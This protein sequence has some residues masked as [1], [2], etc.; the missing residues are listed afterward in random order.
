MLS[1]IVQ[2]CSAQQ[3]CSDTSCVIAAPCGVPSDATRWT[4]ANHSGGLIDGL[5]ATNLLQTQPT[6]PQY[7]AANC[8]GA[9][10]GCHLWAPGFG[11]RNGVVFLAGGSAD[12]TVRSWPVTNGSLPVGPAQTGAGQCLTAQS[13]ADGG[14]DGP[15]AGD[16][17]VMAPCDAG[18]GTH[19]LHFAVAPADG[20]GGGGQAG[21]QA[22]QQLRI[23]S[24]VPIANPL[25]LAGLVPPPPPPPHRPDHF[26]SCTAGLAG[27][28]RLTHA[29]CNDSLP[30]SAR[31]DDL[32]AQL[33]CAEKAAAI[34]SAGAAVPRLGV[35]R[36]GSAED[37]HGV[38]GGCIPAARRNDP[39]SSSSTGC[40]TTFPA[41]PGLGAS[42]DRALWRAVGAAIGVEARGLN[43]ERVGPLYFLDPDINLL[44]D[45]EQAAAP[46]SLAR[47]RPLAADTHTHASFPFP[48]PFR[49]SLGP[50]PRSPRRVPVSHGRVR[51]A[52]D[53]GHADGSRGRAH[54]RALPRRGEH[55]EALSGVR[56]RGL[57][58]QSQLLRHPIGRGVR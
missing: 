28:A 35:P 40:P 49:S 36:L 19:A 3:L 9:D 38:G 52:G 1:L 2:L 45:R 8:P 23:L 44:R 41:G 56:L 47:H 54:R 46:A 10:K 18:G 12:F 15:S 26:Y 57:P 31:L 51:R 43:N 27:G 16:V 55:D 13:V 39:N 11:D 50:R 48:F 17:L 53:P 37:T 21:K 5:T 4:L 24:K 14:A 7:P 25:C 29:F 30:E 6:S 42:F 20:D 32:L 58:A 33:T 34:T 22:G